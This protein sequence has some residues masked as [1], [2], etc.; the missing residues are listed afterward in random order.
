MKKVEYLLRD[1]LEKINQIILA[2]NQRLIGAPEGKMRLSTKPYGVQCYFKDC[3]KE[4]AS[5]GHNAKGNVANTDEKFKGGEN[6]SKKGKSENY[7]NT[8][9]KATPAKE[10]YYK[11]TN[12]IRIDENCW[13]LQL[14]PMENTRK[15]ESDMNIAERCLRKMHRKFTRKRESV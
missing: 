2:A 4:H 13:R 9:S 14:F 1:E 5:N 3:T 8:N 12:C 11:E 6:R 10:A 15:N 7:I